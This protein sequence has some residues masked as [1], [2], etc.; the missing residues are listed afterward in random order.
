MNEKWA[1]TS[2]A[3]AALARN[4]SNVTDAYPREAQS[5]P[6]NSVHKAVSRREE[7][8]TKRIRVAAGILRDADNRVLLA[9]R[10]GDPSFAGLWEFPGGKID[11]GETSGIA[12]KRELREELGIE[13]GAFQRMLEVQ[14]DYADRHVNIEFFLVSNWLGTPSGL[15]GQKLKWVQVELLDETM[16]LPADG[17][18]VTA[19]QKLDA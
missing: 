1:A 9:E 16:L 17:P 11:S 5:F 15:Q 10:L 7:A 19:L 14:H 18:V 6:R 12:L 8:I 3:H 4:S 2:L 13:I